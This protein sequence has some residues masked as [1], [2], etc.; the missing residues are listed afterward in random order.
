MSR[1]IEKRSP[2]SDVQEDPDVPLADVAIDCQSRSFLPNRIFV[3]LQDDPREPLPEDRNWPHQTRCT[4]FA[5]SRQDILGKEDLPKSPTAPGPIAA[6][7]EDS[8][9]VTV[10]LQSPYGITPRETSYVHRP[11][12]RNSKKL[13]KAG[14]WCHG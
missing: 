9:E 2:L 5:A 7:P 1:R 14:L 8:Q 12:I 11:A 6:S 13:D 10:N 3:L 4:E